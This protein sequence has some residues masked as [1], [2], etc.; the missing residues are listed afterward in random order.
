MENKNL[1]MQHIERL[2]HLSL[3][4][5][6]EAVEMGILGRGFAVVADEL[7]R[8]NQHLVELFSAKKYKELSL[9][10][11]KQLKTLYLNIF[12]ECL[13]ADYQKGFVFADEVRKIVNVLS[14]LENKNQSDPLP[15]FEILNK[16]TIMLEKL[17]FICFE[18]NGRLYLENVSFIREITPYLPKFLEDKLTF[19]VRGTKI[20]YLDLQKDFE[21]FS[22]ENIVV[23]EYPVN[24]DRKNQKLLMAFPVEKI[25]FFFKADLGISLKLDND[26]LR[27]I[28]QTDL[29]KNVSFINWR[30]FWG[31]TSFEELSNLEDKLIQLTLKKLENEELVLA[32]KGASPTIKNKFYSNMSKR[33]VEIIEKEIKKLGATPLADIKNAQ[34][35]VVNIFNNL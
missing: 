32:L 17:T 22:P 10:S 11:Q 6:G 35:K 2:Y 34:E 18:I 16:S 14:K 3:I 21:N 30:K 4:L 20:R 5:A 27:E 13:R 12:L 8:V 7:A 23:I 29:N 24:P 1:I 25:H 26:L 9:F 28:W 19:N 33:A 15:Q 31:I